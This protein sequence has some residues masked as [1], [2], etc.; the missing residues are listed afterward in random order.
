MNTLSAQ[1]RFTPPSRPAKASRAVLGLVIL[2]AGASS[3]CGDATLDLVDPDLGLLAH[4][5]FDERQ[6]GA[7]A[8]DSAGFGFD[9]TPSP[10]PPTSTTDAPPVKFH[11]PTSLSFN[12]QDQWL[13]I[14]NPP[15]LDA[16]G[17]IT[18]AAWVRP[19]SVDGYHV[20]PGIPARPHHVHAR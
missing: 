6:T 13:Q 4:W 3:A 16:G 2:A 17:A 10:N 12:G 5:A 7:I 8:V 18:L 20:V 1:P 15:L 9:A 14:G 19:A 11:D